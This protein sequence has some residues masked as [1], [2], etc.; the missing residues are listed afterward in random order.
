MISCDIVIAKT[1]FCV[2]HCLVFV[3][4]LVYP[5]F[6]C[7]IKEPEE[8]K[9]PAAPSVPAEKPG[10]P[11]KGTL[12]GSYCCLTPYLYSQLTAVRLLTS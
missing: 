5:F 7:I 11:K 4:L 3:E 10:V 9:K 2:I 8:V 12:P 1:H 6:D